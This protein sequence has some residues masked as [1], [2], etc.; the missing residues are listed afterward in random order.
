MSDSVINFTHFS[1]IVRWIIKEWMKLHDQLISNSL[2]RCT[3]I[4]K[5]LME[6][7]TK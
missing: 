2:K 1:V 6:M 7:M 4:I 5:M 3:V